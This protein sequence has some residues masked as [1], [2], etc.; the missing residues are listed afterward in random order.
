MLSTRQCSLWFWGPEGAQPAATGATSWAM[1]EASP[2]PGGGARFSTSSLRKQLVMDL[3]SH[4][5]ELK[6]LTRQDH[7]HF[8]EAGPGFP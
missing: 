7:S 4:F 5:L 8:L 3:H 1:A 6:L 2:E